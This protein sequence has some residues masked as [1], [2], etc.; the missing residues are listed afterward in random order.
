MTIQIK[1]A[2]RLSLMASTKTMI[3]DLEKAGLSSEEAKQA[4]DQSGSP[5][6][7]GTTKSK[8]MQ[9]IKGLAALGYK[10]TDKSKH[11]SGVQLWYSKGKD[12][13]YFETDD[14][15]ALIQTF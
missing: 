13:I 9:A 14:K 15:E 2:A 8:A 7:L 1:A 12:S 11:G 5:G 6:G 10:E 4:S 3:A